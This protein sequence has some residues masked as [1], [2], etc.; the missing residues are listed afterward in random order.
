MA[1]ANAQAQRRW[2]ARQKEK[3][4]LHLKLPD[5]PS[6]DSPF[7]RP[8]YQAFEDD[9]NS[10]DMDLY[11]NLC[12]IE[13]VTFDDDRGPRSLTGEFEA[14][15]AEAGNEA[16]RGA[17][18]SLG[19]AE[20]MVGC[21][22]DTAVVLAGVINTYKQSEIRQ[23]IAEIEQSDLN[24]PAVRKAALAQIVRLN[25]LLDVLGKQIRWSFPQWSTDET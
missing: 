18:N 17:K 25:K 6:Q 14:G 19:R 4:L 2:R 21:L 23:R 1:N 5:A 20:S 16:Y 24:D 12:G 11:L 7:I 8:F 22:I 15:A 13:P 9:G 10:I 3:K